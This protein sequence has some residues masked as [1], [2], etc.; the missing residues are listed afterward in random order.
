MQDGS[1][2]LAGVV[3]GTYRVRLFGIPDDA[4]VTTVRRNRAPADPDVVPIDGPTTLDVEIAFDGAVV[5]GTVDPPQPGAVIQLWRGAA[6]P[7]HFA[8]AD[9]D[10]RFEIRGVAPGEYLAVAADGPWRAEAPAKG[11]R[12]RVGPG[13]R[14]ALTLKLQ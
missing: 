9:Q 10:G 3:P 4:Y 1:F 5:G 6:Y 14:A 7:A 12:L 8:S 2:T 11:S 13:E